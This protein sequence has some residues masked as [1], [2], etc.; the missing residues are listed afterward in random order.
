[1]W[2]HAIVPKEESGSYYPPADSL[3]LWGQTRVFTDLGKKREEGISS[4]L[5]LEGSLPSLFLQGVRITVAPYFEPGT[6][7]RFHEGSSGLLTG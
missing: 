1:M 2:A 5:S 7:R 4:F 6:H 3:S